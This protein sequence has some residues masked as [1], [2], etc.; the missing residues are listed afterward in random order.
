MPRVQ[1]EPYH[2]IVI[3]M[4]IDDKQPCRLIAKHLI[5][6]GLKV[7]AATIGRYLQEL[8]AF[9]HKSKLNLSLHHDDIIRMYVDECMS[10]EMIAQVYDQPERK[11]VRSVRGKIVGYLKRHGVYRTKSE[12][13]SH[14]EVKKRILSSKLKKAEERDPV[15]CKHCKSH[16]RPFDIQ[17]IYCLL[18]AQ[19]AGDVGRIKAYGIGRQQFDQMLGTQ[20]G[21]CAI[22]HCSI[23]VLKKQSFAVDHC[24]ETDAVRGI[25]CTKCNHNL[26]VVEA[27]GGE[28]LKS[29]HQYLSKDHSDVIPEL[30]QVN[31]ANL[32]IPKIRKFLP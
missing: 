18:C 32:L 21:L 14:P 30:V 31:D 16:F 11:N 8:G 15:I 22:C 6:L 29:A 4:Y 17:Q 28:W 26:G 24:H 13:T 12:A 23:D 19:V 25:L 1:I 10:P 7:S 20:H 5:D 27:Q 2:D 9:K 3:K